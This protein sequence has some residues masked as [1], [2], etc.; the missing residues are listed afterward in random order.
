MKTIKAPFNFIPLSQKVYIPEWGDLISQDIPFEDGLSGTIDFELQA[1]TPIFIRNASGDRNQK[2]KHSCKSPDGRFMI[3]GTTIKGEIRNILS[4]LSFGKI[5]VGKNVRFAQREWYNKALYPLKGKQS[6]L[7]CGWLTLENNSYVIKSCGKPYRI[8][9]DSIDSYTQ[10]EIF[11]NNFSQQSRQNLN[12]PR[13]IGNI[14]YDP[15]TAVYKYKLFENVNLKGLRFSKSNGNKVKIDM[16]N[17]H[18]TGTVIFTGQPSLYKYPRPK[19]RDNSAGKFY[20]FVFQDK[21]EGTIPIDDDMYRQ[22]ALMYSECEDW[23]YWKSRKQG[24]P[25]FFRQQNGRIKD[26]GLAFLYKLPYEKTVEECTVQEF[27]ESAKDLAECIFGYTENEQSMKGRVQFSAAY[28][29]NAR[30]SQEVRLVLNSPKASYYPIYIKQYI[31]ANG[32][33]NRYYTYND[34]EIAG[35][36]RYVQRAKVISSDISGVSND[37]IST[38]IPLAP[39]ASFKGKIRFHNLREIEL[40]ALLS[41]MTFHN[42]PGCY[43]QF[44]QAKPYGYGRT[45]MKNIRLHIVRGKQADNGYYMA[46]FEKT[47][48]DASKGRW[49]N[50]PSVNELISISSYVIPQRDNSHFDY[51]FHQNNNSEFVDAKKNKEALK[52]FSELTAHKIKITPLYDKY[53]TE[54]DQKDKYAD[55]SN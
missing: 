22:Y 39:G 30:E 28:S 32:T 31:S 19:N 49:I 40:G 43:H 29:D 16:R 35:Y 11:R 13:N 10:R 14:S 42:T 37:M 44:G 25:V 26:F 52:R 54:I 5:R 51:M 12:R 53:K 33:V 38:L 21:I 27:G 1:E 2:D 47:L 50:S 4:I 23:K 48:S 18:I 9:M 6:E 17:G 36:K 41:A 15:K 45:S 8:A 34:G 20:E 55:K 24:I 7:E 3:P 46:L